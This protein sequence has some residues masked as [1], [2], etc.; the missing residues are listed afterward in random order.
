MFITV[1]TFYLGNL[2]EYESLE[3]LFIVLLLLEADRDVD[4]QACRPNKTCFLRF[5]PL[6]LWKNKLLYIVPTYEM[7][8]S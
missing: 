4:P 8:S 2:F 5:V 6:S 3:L 1:H 7:N